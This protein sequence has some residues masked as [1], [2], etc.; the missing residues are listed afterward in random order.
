MSTQYTPWVTS[1][2]L[3]EYAKCLAFYGSGGL[4]GV[5]SQAAMTKGIS[6]EELNVSVFTRVTVGTCLCPLSLHHSA[7]LAGSTTRQQAIEALRHS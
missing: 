2:G 3:R 5:D 4:A 1:V 6:Q 7:M